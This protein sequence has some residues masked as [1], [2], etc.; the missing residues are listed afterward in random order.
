MQELTAS[1]A[2]PRISLDD[3]VTVITNG[4]VTLSPECRNFLLR[5]L[6]LHPK[7]RNNAKELLSHPWLTEDHSS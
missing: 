5:M 1:M 2:V 7:R 6:T 4:S 3:Y